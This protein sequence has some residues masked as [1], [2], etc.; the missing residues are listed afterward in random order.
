MAGARP[1]GGRPP[2]TTAPARAPLAG[3]LVASLV[4]LAD[5]AYNQYDAVALVVTASSSASLRIPASRSRRPRGATPGP[6]PG[7]RSCRPARSLARR[8]ASPDPGPRAPRRGERHVRGLLR[9][10]SAPGPRL[11]LRSPACAP[12]RP[13]RPARPIT[14]IA[15]ELI[16]IMPITIIAIEPCLS[17]AARARPRPAPSSPSP[18]RGPR[19]PLSSHGA[20]AVAACPR[21]RS[22]AQTRA[23]RS[24]RHQGHRTGAARAHPRFRTQ[25]R[26]RGRLARPSCYRLGTLNRPRIRTARCVYRQPRVYRP[27]G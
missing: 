11:R 6:T 3:A 8:S 19:R 21:S 4:A 26:S 10:L 24:R 22:L 12:C 27:D 17:R 16:T 1:D 2:E 9:C 23:P 20:V 25:R 15:I 14:I 18:A 13:V 7:S 5:D